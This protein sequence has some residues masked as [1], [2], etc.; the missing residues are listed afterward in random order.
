[1]FSMHLSRVFH[2]PCQLE[3]IYGVFLAKSDGYLC[4]KIFTFI[5]EVLSHR[6]LFLDGSR[7]TKN[8]LNMCSKG[9]KNFSSAKNPSNDSWRPKQGWTGFSWALKELK[10]L[11]KATESFWKSI[12][13]FKR[14][15]KTKKKIQKVF[16]GLWKSKKSFIKK[17]QI[18][19]RG[20]KSF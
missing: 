16:I 6:K 17:L 2:F 5:S 14:V 4:R 8:S 20:R 3:R 1:M 12:P 7:C 15:Q 10:M 9:F 13:S 18:T 11:H 19:W